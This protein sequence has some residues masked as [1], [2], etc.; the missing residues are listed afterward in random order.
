MLKEGA[1]ARGRGRAVGE[2]LAGAWRPR[3][4]APGLDPAGLDA[5]A[6]L[7]LQTGAG[8]LAWWKIRGSALAGTAPGGRLREAFRRQALLAAV[9]ERQ[10][11]AL[12]SALRAAGVEPLLVKGYAAARLYPEPALRPYGDIDLL[13][14]PEEAPAAAAATHPLRGEGCP[15]DLHGKLGELGEPEEVAR[16]AERI[17]LGE[18]EVRVPGAEDHLR[19]L[20]R[21]LFEHGAWRPLWL[22]DIGAALEARPAGFDWDYFLAGTRQDALAC[23]L[24]LAHRLLGAR[25]EG[26]PPWVGARPVP[27]WLTAALL[28]RWGSGHRHREPLARAI[29]A[30]AEVWDSLGGSWPDPITASAELGAPF[31]RTPR[32][33]Y[34]LA[35]CLRRAA[36]IAALLLREGRGGTRQG[37]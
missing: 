6:P 28:R 20:C 34:Q 21:H 23:A 36:Q 33:P 19:F 1:A 29:Q 32:L 17:P 35:F 7:L 9:H 11:L 25:L 37:S 24:G 26:A 14:R 27:A 2:L 15:V 13:V 12:L 8:G 5:L 22:C 30:R 16:R 10:L 31:D 4:P 18:T 3:P